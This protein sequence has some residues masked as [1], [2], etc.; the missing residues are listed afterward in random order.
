VDAI[1]VHHTSRDAVGNHRRRVRVSV[2]LFYRR[3]GV[4]RNADA[5]RT[6]RSVSRAVDHRPRSRALGR[7]VVDGFVGY[8]VACHGPG[9][10]TLRLSGVS[11]TAFLRCPRSGVSTNASGFLPPR[12]PRHV[13]VRVTAAPAERWI[14]EV[15][16]ESRKFSGLVNIPMGRSIDSST[17]TKRSRGLSAL[18]PRACSSARCER[19]VRSEWHACRWA[20]GVA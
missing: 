20:G 18:L 6:A 9:R 17:A 7:F 5:L 12:V 13:V 4:E 11:E 10:L 8:D 19:S 16:Q 14:V 2:R 15:D 3:G 1:W